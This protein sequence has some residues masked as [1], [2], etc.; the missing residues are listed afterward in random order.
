VLADTHASTG[1][2][3]LPINPAMLIYSALSLGLWAAIGFAIDLLL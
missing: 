2:D 1:A 3:R